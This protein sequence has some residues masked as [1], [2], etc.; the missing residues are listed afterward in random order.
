M[1]IPASVYS[2]HPMNIT[3][4][5]RKADDFLIGSQLF[6]NTNLWTFAYV[7][8]SINKGKQ[9][10]NEAQTDNQPNCIDTRAHKYTVRRIIR[11]VGKK[12]A[13]SDSKR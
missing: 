13:A 5:L 2:L 9:W 10:E 6:S 7:R 11:I 12:N 1:L 8:A 4:K 3:V